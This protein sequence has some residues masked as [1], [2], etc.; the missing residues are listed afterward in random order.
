MR[1]WPA[2]VCRAL[3]GAALGGLAAGTLDTAY[4][5][6]STEGSATAPPLAPLGLFEQGLMAPLALALG[7]A[8]GAFFL[9][10]EPERARGPKGLAQA[11]WPDD[12]ER[13]SRVAAL[14]LG[15]PLGLV[16]WTTACGQWSRL[17]MSGAAAVRGTAMMIAA[18]SALAWVVAATLVL[19][20]TTALTPVVAR[21]ALARHA[22]L[23]LPMGLA[24]AALPLLW[25]MATGTTSGDG[26]F[27]GI[28]GVLR[29]PELDLRPPGIALVLVGGAYL[30]PTLARRLPAWSCLLGAALPL[31]LLARAAGGMQGDPASTGAIE[32]GAPLGRVSLA[33]LRKVTD[34]DHDGASA[35]FGGGD[36]DDRNPSIG[37][38]A[39]DVPGNGVDEDCSGSDAPVPELAAAPRIAS[40]ADLVPKGLNVVLITVDTL[41]ADLGFAGNP[42]PLSPNL[43]RLAARA[44]V[45]DRAYSLA[46]YTGK[47]V[48]PLMTGKYPSETHRGWGHFNSYPRDDV[49]VAERLQ[50]AGVHTVGVQAHWYFAPT[51]GLSRGFDTWD[52]SAVPPGGG[53]DDDAL[54]TGGKLTDAVLKVLSNAE[55]TS[56]QFF[57]WIHYLDP[58]SEYARH[59]GAPDLGSGMR[60]LYDGEV[61]YADQQIGR[62][63]DLVE[64][65]PWGKNTAIIVTSD[66]GE[67]F[68]EHHM[69]RHGFELWEELVRVPLV[70]YVPGAPPHR[71]AV[72][73]SAIDLVPTILDLFQVP[74]PDGTD[75]ND[76]VSGQSL[77]ADIFLPRSYEPQQR[78]I[79]ID[80]PAG[81]HNDERRAFIHDDTKLYVAGGVRYQLFDLAA[82]PEEKADRA[83]DRELLGAARARYQAFRA[84]LH[85]IAVKPVAKTE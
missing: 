56:R 43:D 25:G 63:L 20:W 48:G 62:V 47:S 35:L 74:A 42:K 15:A 39:I 28:W 65:E 53:H 9:V 7:L 66:H 78:D 69:I 80:M 14:A 76:F 60:A 2:R 73:R 10:V 1:G 75:R 30:G 40:A 59:P 32:R 29:R 19:A 27:F 50:K 33:L 79:F 5:W 81:P 72:R 67:A 38:S 17:C 52:L 37:P 70:V 36:C 84:S 46:S 61:W 26:G 41:R 51:F 21:S 83:A 68:G 22:P 4:A 11:L 54:V 64:R 57:A 24:L 8:V 12:P 13:R 77:A 6:R 16:A 49:M 55:H 71:V 82:D 3:L 45:F 85:E 31:A 44:V 34:R 58:H 18:G 23:S